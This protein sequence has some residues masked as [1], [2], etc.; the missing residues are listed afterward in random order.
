MLFVGAVP[1]ACVEQVFRCV[2]M[3]SVREAFICCS[4]SFRFEHAL[5]GRFP[6][7]PVHSNDVSLFSTAIGTHAVGDPRHFRFVKEFDGIEKLL[8]RRPPLDRLVA[9]TITVRMCHFRGKNEHAVSHRRH[10]LANFEHYLDKSR[11]RVQRYVE[12]LKIASFFAGDF[13]KQAAAAIERGGTIFAWPPTHKGDYENF[14]K[15]VEAGVE[16][17]PP[18]Y[19]LWNPTQIGSW[20]H[21]LDKTGVD[22]V[23]CA[24]RDLTEEGVRPFG[25]YAS[26]RTQSIYLYAN[27]R[28]T[29]TLITTE[30]PAEPFRY[31]KVIPAELQP[32]TFVRVVQ[33]G[34]KQ[35]NFIKDVYQLPGLIHTPGEMSFLVFLGGKLAGGFVYAT[36]TYNM[37]AGDVELRAARSLY[38]LS[39][40]SVTRDGKVSKLI[41]MLSTGREMIRKYERWRIRRVDHLVTTAFSNRPASMKYRGIFELITRKPGIL[42]YWSPVRE[43]SYADIYRDWFRRYHEAAGQQQGRRNRGRGGGRAE[44]RGPAQ[45]ADR[46]AQAQGAQAAGEERAL[47]AGPAVPA[48]G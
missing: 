12:S 31:E 34:W 26:G 23:V 39:D 18:A 17:E 11:E 38:L 40:F 14:Y 24:N 33:V 27:L 19:D 35:M 9:L 4:G 48:T 28:K 13:R 20:I 2:D 45:Q 36:S 8:E 7:V 42:N 37:R 15:T 29:S 21:E 22:Y 6:D 3:A 43:Q 41:S 1:K 10:M 30:T 47:H 46:S 5:A 25:L 44:R 16:W 32:D